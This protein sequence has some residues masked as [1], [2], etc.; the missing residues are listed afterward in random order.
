MKILIEEIE[1]LETWL[2]GIDGNMEAEDWD[3]AK[4]KIIDRL[5]YV[6]GSLVRLNRGQPIKAIDPLTGFEK[7]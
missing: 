7:D 4:E 3:Y 2:N 5:T 6:K 1:N